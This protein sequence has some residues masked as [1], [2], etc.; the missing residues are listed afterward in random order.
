VVGLIHVVLFDFLRRQGGDDLVR[1]VRQRAGISAETSFRIDQ[2]Y[3]DEEWR[4]IFAAVCETLSME[5]ERVEEV[6]AEAFLKDVLTR[7]P[8]FFRM[9][10]NSREFLLRQPPI[11][12]TFMSSVVDPSIRSL[13][14]EKFSVVTDGESILTTYR[15]PNGH[16]HLYVTLA[17]AILAHYGDEGSVEQLECRKNG[18]SCCTFRVTWTKLANPS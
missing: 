3:P 14:E 17:R 4:R 2:A 18:A 10:K 7:F 5:A 16:C 15:S 6:F 9:A 13:G 12:T 1:A 8:A 11:H